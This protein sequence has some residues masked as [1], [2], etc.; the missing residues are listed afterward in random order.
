MKIIGYVRV[1][2]DEQTREGVSL[3]A[4]RA[5]L[6]R[7]CA[8]Q[9][10][11]KPEVYSDE[12][13]SGGDPVDKRPGLLAAL[14]QLSKGAALVVAKRDR[15]ARDVFL[16]CWIE[17]EV[18]RRRAKVVSLAGEGTEGDDPAAI[19]M[20]RMVDA[21]AEYERKLIG[22][23]TKA[24]LGHKRKNSQCIGVIPYG[25]DLECDGSRPSQGKGSRKA[26]LIENEAEQA[27]IV[28]IKRL[29]KLGVR[30]AG[31]ARMLTER[32]I[33]TKTG[34]AAWSHQAVARILKRAG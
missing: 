27:V 6:E 22:A 4:Q 18:K 34:R 3:D 11:A 32:G 2:T 14:E 29:R 17:K 33:P 21:F 31:I 19:L 20:R 23:R 30:L 13:V 26:R 10:Y 24:A 15:L 25:F 7:W 28:E 1:S 9:G 8:A 12:G 16:S 5:D